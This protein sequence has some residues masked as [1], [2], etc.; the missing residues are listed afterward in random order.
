MIGGRYGRGDDRVMDV[1]KYMFHGMAAI[2]IVDLLN[3]IDPL[4]VGVS[5]E[6]M[7]DFASMGFAFCILTITAVVIDIFGVVRKWIRTT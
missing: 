5:D 3:W 2:L 7:L 4:L 6:I 1:R